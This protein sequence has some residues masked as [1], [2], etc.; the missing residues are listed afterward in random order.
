MK[1]RL[2]HPSVVRALMQRHGFAARRTF[3]QNFLIDGHALADIV[4]A[5][6][7][8]AR[9]GA[10]LE[11]GPGAG[12]LTQALA[13]AGFPCVLAIEKDSRLLPVL[14][15]TVGDYD[16]VRIVQGDALTADFH[17]LLD[18]WQG[19]GDLRLVANLPYYI[20]TPLLMKA[21][22]SEAGFE[23]IVVMVQ[24][25]VALRMIAA[26]G[27][28]DYGAL[29]LAVQYY[30]WAKI[31][32]IV[33]A[34]CFLPQPAVDSAVVTLQVKPARDR[35]WPEASEY[36]RIVRG[37]F[38]RRRKTLANALAAEFTELSKDAVGA[39]LEAAGIA[40]MRRGETLAAEDFATLARVRYAR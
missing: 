25:E 29:T 24:K 17:A 26:P 37:A 11:I 10:V 16:S 2:Y 40:P 36:F 9:C 38:G 20:T 5:A 6:G 34:G 19:S 14:R 18:S 7:D 32:R 22:E 33:T 27:T 12:A 21:L 28:R 8:P 15:E 39:W 35:P 31:A 13:E 4:A 30:A 23:R 1:E 3:G